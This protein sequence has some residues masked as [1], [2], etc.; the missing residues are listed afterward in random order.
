MIWPASFL[1]FFE[2]TINQNQTPMLINN[3]SSRLHLSGTGAALSSREADRR[4]IKEATK[5]LRTHAEKIAWHLAEM[6]AQQMQAHLPKPAV[7]VAVAVAGSPD[8]TRG[9]SRA[10]KIRA[11]R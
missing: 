10:G 1:L 8:G 9:K 7:A 3:L 5:S 2:I 4:R 6:A 11:G